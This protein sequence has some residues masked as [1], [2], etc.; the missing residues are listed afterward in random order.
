M[1]LLPC[2]GS[3]MGALRF[4]TTHP[5]HGG[6][7]ELRRC[8]TGLSGASAASSVEVILAQPGPLHTL[9]SPCKPARVFVG[10]QVLDLVPLADSVTK[11]GGTCAYCSNRALFSLR[12]AADE[13]QALVGGADKYAPVCR[14][15][16]TELNDL[17]VPEE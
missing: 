2:I 15:H 10:M 3:F 8:G 1:L 17:R 4:A 7:F 6:S 5:E 12:I 9:C 13:R 16:Y 11:L 14:Q